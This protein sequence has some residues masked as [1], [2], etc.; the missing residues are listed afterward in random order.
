MAKLKRNSAMKNHEI[1]MMVE[2]CQLTDEILDAQ[3]PSD[4]HI[5]GVVYDPKNRCAYIDTPEGRMRAAVGD[6]IVRNQNGD[7][8]FCKSDEFEA[9]YVRMDKPAREHAHENP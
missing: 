1:Q 4:L 3:H 7:L 2:A 9:I 6:Y 5:P 8:Y